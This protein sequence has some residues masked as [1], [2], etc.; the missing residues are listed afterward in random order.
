M[1]IKLSPSILSADFANLERDIKIAV[2][3]GAEYDETLMDRLRLDF[4]YAGY[5]FPAIV[6]WNL[7]ATNTGAPDTI[8]DNVAMVSGYSPRILRAVFS[9]DYSSV[10]R[11][12]QLNPLEVMEHALAPI[13]AVLN[14][15]RLAPLP[16]ALAR[17]VSNRTRGKSC[18]WP[19]RNLE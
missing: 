15:S 3:A 2:D 10:T 8:R 14:L 1:Q 13:R 7:N 12:V 9:S 4:K 19:G 5:E 17:S 6:Y 16:R 18:R 11:P